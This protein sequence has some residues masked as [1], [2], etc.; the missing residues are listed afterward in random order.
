ME[1]KKFYSATEAAKF[2]CISKSTMYCYL[3]SGI[4]PSIHLGQNWKVPKEYL[5]SLLREQNGE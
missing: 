5:D 1:E 3:K 4:V 2:L